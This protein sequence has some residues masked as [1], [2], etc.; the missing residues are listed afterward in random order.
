MRHTRDLFTEASDHARFADPR[1]TY[2]QRHLTFASDGMFPTIHQQAQFVL[3]PDEWGQ[4]TR[5]G[6]RF[7]ASAYSAGLDYPV[8]LDRPFDALERLRS[9]IFNYE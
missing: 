4:T 9:A 6:H 7:E 2:Y 1:F 5:R 3:A 8:K